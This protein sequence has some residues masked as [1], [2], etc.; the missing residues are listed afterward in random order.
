MSKPTNFVKVSSH[1]VLGNKVTVWAK[2]DRYSRPVLGGNAYTAT[3]NDR[4]GR[5]TRPTADAHRSFDAQ[6]ACD[7][8]RRQMKKIA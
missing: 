1:V 5:S 7:Y 6:W 2:A 8:L 4:L 3:C